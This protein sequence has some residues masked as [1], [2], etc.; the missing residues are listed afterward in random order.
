MD[1]CLPV[2]P[3]ASGPRHPLPFSG[4]SLNTASPVP[5]WA[6]TAQAAQ[7]ALQSLRPVLHSS[8]LL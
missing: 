6:L 1:P 4:P 8:P 7:L 3:W 2:F 5:R